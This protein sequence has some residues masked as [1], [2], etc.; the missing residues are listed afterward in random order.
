MAKPPADPVTGYARAVL[1]GEIV[2]GRLVRMSCQ[3]HLDDLETGPARGLKWDLASALRVITF[4]ETVLCLNGGEHEGK[5]FLLEP[6]Q[7]FLLGCLF[8]WRGADGFRRFRQAYVEIG[9]GN[10]KSPIAAGIGLYLLLA[11]S[12]PR[13]EVYAA[14]TKVDQARV[15]FRDAVAMVRQSQPLGKALELSGAR[16]R[17]WNIAH[18]TSGSWFRTVSSEDNGQS[19]PRPHCALIDEI[20]EHRTSAVVNMMR[21]GTKG[22]RQAMIFEITNSGHDKTSVCWDHHEYSVK[23]LQG[24]V[25]NDAWFAY[26]C[27][28]DPCAKCEQEGKT[29]PADDCPDCD[30]WKDARCWPKAN[31]NLGV[32]IHYRYL[33]EQVAEAS[34]MP[35]R[36]ADVKRLNFCLWTE[37]A[38]HAVPMDAWDACG[39][40]INPA[41]LQGRSAHYALDI[42]STSDFTALV[43][44]FPHDDQEVVEVAP[45]PS[46]PEAAPLKILRR[47]YTLVP[48]FWLPEKPRIRSQHMEAVIEN[49]RRAGLIRTTPGNVV[50]YDLVLEDIARLDRL[51][52]MLD[53]TV[54]RGFQGAQFSTNLQ[55]RFGQDMVKT[56]AQG[57][58]S[59]NAPFREFLELV[60]LGRLHHGKHPVMRWMCANC[61]AETR[62]GL[63]KPS[64]DRSDEKIDGV[65]AV[66]MA[67][68]Q[69]MVRRGE[70]DWYKPGVLSS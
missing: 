35:T 11:D 49:W 62:G 40:D 48:H 7:K 20:H 55:N 69:A 15:L 34:E 41:S 14:A 44:L 42:G 38:V 16:D 12:E 17:E 27:T 9:K 21:A 10:G 25:G 70:D 50:D 46:T 68:G 26:V 23:V 67:L 65:T 6:W 4:F 30:S 31:P 58:L 53:I 43:Q 33:R 28:L 39:G 24:L 2:A 45:D 19:G 66:T 37:A 22:R 1:S 47:S 64:K 59:M 3:R 36:A 52:P 54:D 51:Q 18:H 60:K 61:A 13:A 57:I 29:Q 5:P 8:G 63:I 32:S 56:F